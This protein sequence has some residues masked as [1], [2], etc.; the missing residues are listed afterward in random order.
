MM[1]ILSLF[2]INDN[3]NINMNTKNIKKS[4]IGE[5]IKI[6][7]ENLGLPR[8]EISKQLYL[9][10]AICG[11]W[12]RGISNPSTA[13]LIKLAEVLKVSFDWLATGKEKV[14]DAESIVD[15][16]TQNIQISQIV[17]KLNPTQ[18]TKLLSFLETIVY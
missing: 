4:T 1:L 15:E 17:K 16:T 9:S 14:A 12:E 6:A 3:E 7:R 10:P 18:K 8:T 2:F 11:Q 5:R 13:H